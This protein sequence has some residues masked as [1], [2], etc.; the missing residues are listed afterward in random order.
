MIAGADVPTVVV[1]MYAP[2]GIA[3]VYHATICMPW[4]FLVA[5][6]H[7]EDPTMGAEIVTT[8]V[9][10]Y[11]PPAVFFRFLL[12]ELLW[13]A[14][15]LQYG[16]GRVAGQNFVVDGKAALRDGAVPDFVIP[17]TGAFKSAPLGTKNLL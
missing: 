9:T 4:A 13:D 6:W 14:S 8:G 5:L 17:A 7:V 12:S 3:G 10:T 1:G 11:A 15:L 16:I 2:F